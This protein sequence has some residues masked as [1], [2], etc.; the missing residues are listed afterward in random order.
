MIQLLPPERWHELEAIFT[1]E[2]NAVLPDPNHDAIIV[3]EE[4]GELIGFCV[5]ETLVR[6][7]NF[8][9]SEKHR[10]NGTVKR[11]IDFVRERAQASGR[12]FVAFADEPRYERLFKSLGMR[13]VGTAWRR[14]F[15]SKEELR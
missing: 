10:G 15:F 12:S 14:D 11:L 9:V 2:W 5:I 8:F 4:D 7:G 3:E 1:D 6:T 13:P